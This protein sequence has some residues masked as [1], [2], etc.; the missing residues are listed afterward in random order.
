MDISCSKRAHVTGLVFSEQLLS[1]LLPLEHL[2]QNVEDDLVLLYVS[3]PGGQHQVALL[4]QVPVSVIE[5]LH[6]VCLPVMNPSFPAK[7]ALP[8]L[9]LPQ[10]LDH[11]LAVAGRQIAPPR[12]D[13]LLICQV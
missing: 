2:L 8:F 6:L 5:A 4:R 7:T 10:H 1:F 9:Q 3:D 13:D 12:E 11:L